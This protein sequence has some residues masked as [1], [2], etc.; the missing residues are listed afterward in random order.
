MNAP[1]ELPNGAGDMI[2]VVI[3]LISP[4]IELI[5]FLVAGIVLCFG[6]SMRFLSVIADVLFAAVSCL[7]QEKDFA[8]SHAL[9]AGNAQ[10]AVESMTRTGDKGVLTPQSIM[11]ST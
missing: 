8:V 1:I 10:E 9:P 11:P 7:P 3:V 5:S 6:F 2:I 4:G